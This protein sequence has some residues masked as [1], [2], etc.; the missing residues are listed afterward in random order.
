MTAVPVL[1]L[2][3]LTL[4]ENGNMNRHISS[5][6][7]LALSVGLVISVVFAPTAGFAQAISG[8]V[9]GTVV[10]STGAAVAGAEVT[11][12]NVG[13]GIVTSGKTN[14][15]GEYRFDNLL[16]GTYKV[17]ARAAGFRVVTMQVEIRL[18]QTG[19]ANITLPP[20]A[21][22]ETVEVS[23]TAP[24]IDTTT[25]QL[26]NTYEAKQLQDLPTTSLGLNGPTGQN[27]G[28]LNLVLLDAGVGSSGGLGG[29]TGPSV[30]GQ[31]PH[32]NNFTVEGVDNND[33]GVT[34]PLIYVPSDA[35][36]NFS[37][38]QN[39]FSPEFG[40]STGGQFNI[41]VNSGTN[42]FHGRA[43]EFFQNRN[44]N[45][46]DYDLSNQGILTNP[47]FDSNRFGG[48]L[49][50]PIFKNKLFFFVNYEYNPIGEAAVLGSPILAPTANGYATAAAALTAQG[51]STA[52]LNAL[53]AYALSPSACT[54]A[55]VTAKVCPAATMDSGGNVISPAGTLPLT[56]LPNGS[57]I[58]VG[59]L[60]VAAPNFSNYTAL[61]T[62]MDYNIS[63]RDQ[64]RG[65]Y[66]YNKNATLDT[67]AQLPVF[68]TPLT[69]PFHLVALSEYHTFSPTVTNEFRVGYNR[70][71]NNFLDPNLKFLPTLD[72]FPN[73]V[74]DN[75]GNLNVGPNP[76]APQYATQNLYQAV[77]NVTWIKGNHTVKVGLE[78]RRYISPQKFI[79]R[80]RGS[81]DWTS[82]NNFLFDTVPDGAD[83]QRSFGTAGYSGDQYGIFTYVNDIWKL[84]S[85]LSVNLGLRYEYTSTPY[86]W[87]QQ[88][89][90]S[91]ANVPGL[92]TFGSPQAPTKDFMPR[93]GFAYSP[94]SSGNTSIRGG[95]G[96]G[97]DVLFDNIGTLSR[98]PQ[99]GSTTQCPNPV[100]Q[101][102]F[103]ANGGIPLKV[104]SGI[105]VLDPATARANTSA[106]LPN[107]VQYPYSESWNLGVQHVF[108]KDYT[109]DVRYVGTRGIDLDVQ[110]W[111]NFQPV[112]TPTN[113]LPTY[114]QAPSQASLDARTLNLGQ[115]ET[116]FNNGGF[117]VPAYLNAGFVNP[118][119]AYMPWGASTYHGLQTQLT[120]RFSNGLHFQLAYTFSHTVDNS[121]A[122]F[123]TTD[124]APRRPQDF[125]NLPSERANSILDHR[126]RIT[127][128]AIYDA[129]WYSHSS[130]WLKRNVLGNYEIAP[131]Y[132]WESGQWGTVQS[133]LDSNLNADAA[134]DRAIVNPRGVPGTSSTVLNLCNSAIVATGHLCNNDPDPNFDP[135]PFVVAYQAATPSAQYIT[136]GLGALANS[137]RSTLAT[138]PINNWDMSVS[139][140]IAITER[141]RLDLM[142]QALN[143]LNHPEF[144]TGSPNQGL[145][146]TTVGSVRNLLIPG[147]PNFNNPKTSF[148]SNAR[149]LQLALKFSF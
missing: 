18:N 37:V 80:S 73:I 24:I 11:A 25:A 81:Y 69:I 136:A 140:H 130:S 17:A 3:G 111:L 134:G 98:P 30:S 65:R 72:A 138:P 6:L 42:S 103:L 34:G 137:S 63:D 64:I 77:D 40:H 15:T 10:D 123:H 148:A 117:Y 110:N 44:L 118:V 83:Q 29:G 142:V 85:N 76:S 45:A 66:I 12:A 32:N 104:V 27:L 48:Q 126:H 79:Q 91:V 22:S 52:N 5:L 88:A 101:T 139:K 51:K 120:R 43:Y 47:R 2:S 108:A 145:T 105:T 100:C 86:G 74:I 90:N 113:S 55:Q 50:G 143:A 141:Y 107:N 109:A 95:F 128:S 13:T 53:K 121:T 112:A 68:F 132:T 16:V 89:L 78:G 102:P 135:S 82:V 129:P 8:N 46:V 20:G 19:T 106:F 114:L 58:E 59:I 9:V 62:S 97:Y 54:A 4:Q 119:I 35:V 49:G 94:G 28:V 93:V 31:R 41:V 71:G 75:L 125:L 144:V 116:E 149:T 39:Q 38:L 23:G 57:G 87:T 115:L 36:S 84:R 131:V 60:P 33:K 1:V 70:T 26:E 21:T 122:D 146:I 14:S 133:G 99:I 67:A 56:G 92:I 124:I 7:L 61:T 96:L 127:I 147:S